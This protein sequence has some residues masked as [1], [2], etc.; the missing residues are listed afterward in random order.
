MSM[1]LVS[2]QFFSAKINAVNVNIPKIDSN[3]LLNNILNVAYFVAGAVAV[4]S[5]VIAGFVM[6]NSGQNPES[7]KTA[8]EQILYSVV[9]LIVII[10]AF[11]VTQ[12]VYGRFQ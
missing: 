9:G 5:I 7:V 1:I 4:F 3:L 2:L 6:V 12:F 8:R 11:A 10:M